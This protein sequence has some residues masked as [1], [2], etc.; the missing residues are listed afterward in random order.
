MVEPAHRVGGIVPA[1]VLGIAERHPLKLQRPVLP[2]LRAH[3]LQLP[4][5]R[6]LGV[7]RVRHPRDIS[8]LH[9]TTPP[10]HSPPPIPR[11]AGLSAVVL[12]QSCRG[13]IQPPY[14]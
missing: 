4:V 9:D 10:G 13:P 6:R 5:Q 3:S 2:R 1:A 11:T 12:A 7:P 8:A 14:I